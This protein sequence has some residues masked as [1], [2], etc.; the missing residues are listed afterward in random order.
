MGLA[1]LACAL[2]LAPAAAAQSAPPLVDQYTEQIPTADGPKHSGGG[3]AATNGGGTLPP[4]VQAQ[5]KS[6]GGKDA[7]KLK[8]LATSPA[9]GAPETSA[10]LP[11]GAGRDLQPESALSAA[12][13]AI[14]DGSDGRLVGLFVALLAIAAA[15]LG[16]AAAR[17][18][19]GF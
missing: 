10:R 3:G 12:I 11:E 1:A 17:R 18:Q 14:S 6:E 9:F 8:E 13:T 2:M 5:I 7:K 15:A 16:V 19:R 4:G